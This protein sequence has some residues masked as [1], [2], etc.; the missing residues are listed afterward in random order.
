MAIDELDDTEIIQ[1]ALDDWYLAEEKN[2]TV[3]SSKYPL[4]GEVQKQSSKI[5][6]MKEWCDKQKIV[7]T[8]TI[9]INGFEIPN[10][11]NVSDLRNVLT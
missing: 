10:E 3:F 4:N 6:A 5:Q 7:H 1:K 11:Y 9:F 8:P 2:Y